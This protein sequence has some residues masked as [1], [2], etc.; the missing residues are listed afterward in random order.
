MSRPRRP[1][2]SGPKR[3]EPR[4]P[5]VY[6]QRPK[7]QISC[8]VVFAL[9]I[10]IGLIGV[11]VGIAGVRVYD[12]LRAKHL[13]ELTIK[14]VTMD[15]VISPDRSDVTVSANGTSTELTF[16]NGTYDNIPADQEIWLLIQLGGFCYPQEGP[17]EKAAAGIWRHGPIEFPQDGTQE[18]KA[19]L[20]SP[21]AAAELRHMVGREPIH[22]DQEG[23]VIKDSVRVTVN[24]PPLPDPASTASVEIL[25]PQ[26]GMVVDTHRVD[27]VYGEFSGIKE[28]EELWLIVFVGSN[29]Y[30]QNGPA[31]LAHTDNS[32]IHAE[33]YLGEAGD[34]AKPVRYS[35]I[36]VIVHQAEDQAFFRA[37]K[38]GQ[39]ISE[40]P[41]GVTVLPSITI[42]RSQ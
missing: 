26:D 23:V 8:S 6:E 18:I 30:I 2:P 32:W 19:V 25:L 42:I 29:L 24:P 39:P 36:P 17:A 20:V 21:A 38:D 37:H 11:G 28:D 7:R 4:T 15:A 16:V 40:L 10:G 33:I 31:M 12:D 27:G 22:C 13:P 5:G 9:L 1:T 3:L 14:S 35:L 41:D 34:I